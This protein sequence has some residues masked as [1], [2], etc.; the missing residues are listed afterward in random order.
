MQFI[1]DES[2]GASVVNHLRSEGHDV[3][4]VAEAMPRASDSDVL[5]RA[6]QEGRIL[7]T[8]DKDFGDLVF[9]SGRCH[10]GVL[11]LRLRDESPANRVRVVQA[12]LDQHAD[13]LAET[14]TVATESGVR[15]RSPER[16]P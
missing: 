8:N 11:L 16:S 13:R 7:I 4:A 9:R 2:T 14:F 10:F 5:T 1:V 15:I 12:V 6:V 3:L